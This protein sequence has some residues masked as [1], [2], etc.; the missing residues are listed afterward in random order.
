MVQS[1]KEYGIGIIVNEASSDKIGG[2]DIQKVCI[3][4]INNF[5]KDMN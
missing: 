3:T 5:T 4:A 2:A 1:V